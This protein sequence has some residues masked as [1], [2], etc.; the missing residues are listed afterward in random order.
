MTDGQKI[1]LG[2]LFFIAAIVVGYIVFCLV[3]AKHY[4]RTAGVLAANALVA[5]LALAGFEPAGALTVWLATLSF[6]FV[7]FHA[8][9]ADKN[10]S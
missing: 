2:V 9:E 7:V 4:P 8:I 6:F 10:S 1:G 3:P 5:G